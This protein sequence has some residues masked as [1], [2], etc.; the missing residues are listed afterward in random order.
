MAD[1]GLT[2][3]AWLERVPELVTRWCEEW[4][5]RLGEPYASGA[6]G[7]TTRAELA[8]GRPAVLKLVYPHRESEHEADALE[9][10]N[11]NGAVRLLA[12]SG[13]GLAMLIERCV[14]GT[15]LAERGAEVSLDVLVALLPRLWVCGGEPV[16]TL[17]DEAA[18]WVSY[19]PRQWDEV[20]PPYPRRVLDAALDALTSLPPT[21][22]EL[23]LL[24]QD[25]HG[26]NVLAAQ[27]EPWLVIDPKPLLGEREFAVAPIVR[28][29]EL[30]HSRKDVLHRFDRL[31]GELGLD[32]ER[33]RGWAIGQTL[34]W[35]DSHWSVEHL[36]TAL[37][38]LE[39]V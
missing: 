4:D 30:G 29:F 24:H 23:V 6:G 31:T 11:G 3:D 9:L 25:L 35:F 32:R 15:P 8:D 39:G 27:R 17:T 2:H 10:W 12:R 26:E 33:A 13:D 37:W 18:G 22:G 38:L 5:L 7:H 21:Q 19:L 34:A 28:S 20:R 1:T 14:P 16:H 36:D